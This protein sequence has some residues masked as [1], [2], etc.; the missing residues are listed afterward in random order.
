[1]TWWCWQL[2]PTLPEVTT[3][4]PRA[5]ERH[6]IGRD[7]WPKTVLRAE[8]AGQALYDLLSRPRELVRFTAAGGASRHCEP[9]GMAIR[10]R[11]PAA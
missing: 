1:V 5:V 8:D 11:C 3:Q 7:R 10:D 4:T 9:M 6:G 2:E